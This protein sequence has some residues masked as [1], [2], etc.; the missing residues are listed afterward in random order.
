MS[1]NAV[2]KLQDQE[3]QTNNTNLYGTKAALKYLSIYKYEEFSA[4]FYTK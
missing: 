3:R 4:L 1:P 2:F